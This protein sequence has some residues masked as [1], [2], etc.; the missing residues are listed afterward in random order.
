MSEQNMNS[1][2]HHQLITHIEKL[3]AKNKKLRK[4]C[5][6]FQA[7]Y[8]ELLP[9]NKKLRELL[10]KNCKCDLSGKVDF[11]VCDICYNLEEIDG[12]KDE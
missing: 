1:W 5:L 9:I 10:H 12:G 6:M 3:K 8:M 4:D 2:S 7:R 11:G